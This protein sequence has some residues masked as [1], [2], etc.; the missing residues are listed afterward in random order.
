MQIQLW[1]TQWRSQAGSP[2][3]CSKPVRTMVNEDG[4]HNGDPKLT[5][6]LGIYI[7]FIQ[8]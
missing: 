3:T 8:R 6:T 1:F 5:D 2:K 7:R 4:S